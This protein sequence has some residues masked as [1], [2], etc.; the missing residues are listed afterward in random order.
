MNEVESRSNIL[1]LII[2]FAAFTFLGIIL[3]YFYVL[4][5]SNIHDVWINVIAAFAVGALFALMVWGLKRLL[6]VTNNALSV[7]VVVL[8]LVIVMYVMWS[9]WIALVYE[10]FLFGIEYRVFADFGEFF[11]I[12]RRMIFEH[13]G[14]NVARELV[15]DLRF[16]NEQGT[17]YINDNVWSGFMLTGVWIGEFLVITIPPIMAAYATAGIYLTELNA[18]VQEKLMNYGFTAFDDYELD[19]LAAGDIQVILDKP[20][21]ARNGP[22][23]AVAV[24]YLDD[25]PTE[26]IAVYKA[27]WD[28]EGVLTKGRHIMTVKLGLDKIDALDVGLQ[29]IHY[30]DIVEEYEIDDTVEEPEIEVDDSNE[31][32]PESTEDTEPTVAEA[33][34]APETNEPAEAPQPNEPP[35]RQRI[36]INETILKATPEPAEPPSLE[37]TEEPEPAISPEPS[38]EPQPAASP[39][40]AN[41]PQPEPPEPSEAAVTPEPPQ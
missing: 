7:I 14:S 30:P 41:A 2:L 37:P 3:S 39:E 34:Q 22:M 33:S 10:R 21:E 27:T 18:W 20:L 25:E 26:F 36:R 12:T 9:M 11:R 6:K 24:C 35:K 29:A 28:N 5:Q 38:E 31:Q 19:R 1:G 13:H 15:S 17:W 40:P 23:N 32:S 16:I 4:F 8:S